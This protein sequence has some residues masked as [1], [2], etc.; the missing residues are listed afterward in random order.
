MTMVLK[1]SRVAIAAGVLAAVSVSPVFAD[2][3]AFDTS[4]ASP[5]VYFGTGNAN[6]GFTTLTT[7]TG[8]IEL[9]LGV[10]TRG[11]GGGPVL[12]TPTSGSA[13]Y[14]APNGGTT[15][16][17]WNYEFSVNLGSS[18]L[19][20]ANIEN[21]GTSLAVVNLTTGQAVVYNPSLVGDNAALHPGNTTTNGGGAAPTDIGFQNSENLGFAGTGFG[22]AFNANALDTYLITLTVNEGNGTTLS[23]SETVNAV[24]EASTWAMMILGF[25]GVGFLAYRRRNQTA[26]F[27]LV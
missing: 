6:A 22:S 15:L 13:L 1:C 2:T 21:S 27:R 14:N 9:G 16:A 8:G 12:P 17:L 10:E 18:G 5:G 3:L 23:I 25:F 11:P 20:L 4:L 19:T 26:A 24:P 7:T